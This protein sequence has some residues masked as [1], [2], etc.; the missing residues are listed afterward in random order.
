[1]QTCGRCFRDSLDVQ[2]QDFPWLGAFEIS[3]PRERKLLSEP[4]TESPRRIHHA[5]WKLFEASLRSELSLACMTPSLIET[6]QS[7]IPGSKS[8]ALGHEMAGL[9]STTGIAHLDFGFEWAQLFHRWRQ[10]QSEG[11][12]V[13]AS[14]PIRRDGFC[15]F[16]FVRFWVAQP[17]RRV[18]RPPA[19]TAAMERPAKGPRYAQSRRLRRG[20]AGR[21][22]SGES[23]NLRLNSWTNRSNRLHS[24]P[25]LDCCYVTEKCENGLVAC[26]PA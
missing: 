15:G 11:F 8:G 19:R 25:Q 23:G 6:S 10:V 5:S 13:S 16:L 14:T 24:D 3:L 4:S 21:P 2:S 9:Q 1:M 18:A 12:S 26:Q 7:A 22:P 17:G 20:T